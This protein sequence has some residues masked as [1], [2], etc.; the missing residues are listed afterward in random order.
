MRPAVRGAAQAAAGAGRDVEGG[1]RRR[2]HLRRLRLHRAGVGLQ[3][4]VRGRPRLPAIRGIR[5]GG[6]SVA[7]IRVATGGA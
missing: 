6:E 4:G 2:R 3:D 1:G 7:K 5:G